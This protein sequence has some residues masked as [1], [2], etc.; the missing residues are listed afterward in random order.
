M[1]KQEA[2]IK[3]NKISL[4]SPLGSALLNKTVGDIV[5]IHA[6]EETYQVKILSVNL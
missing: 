4:V 3:T 6:P 2:D 5:T 1:G